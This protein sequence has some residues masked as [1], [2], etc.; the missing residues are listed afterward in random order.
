MQTLQER[1]KLHRQIVKLKSRLQDMGD[2]KKIQDPDAS[3]KLFQESKTSTRDLVYTLAVWEQEMLKPPRR[4]VHHKLP[5]TQIESWNKQI[6][7]QKEQLLQQ[8]STRLQALQECQETCRSQMQYELHSRKFNV[9]QMKE[10]QT[11]LQSEIRQ[12]VAHIYNLSPRAS[13]RLT[14][15]EEAK[16]LEQPYPKPPN[17][18]LQDTLLKQHILPCPRTDECEWYQCL[19][20]KWCLCKCQLRPHCDFCIYD[21]PSTMGEQRKTLADE[22]I[23]RMC[24]PVDIRQIVSTFSF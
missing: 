17:K 5:S 6:A 21:D 2:E 7:R 4:Q 9:I 22:D 15:K 23:A 1:W 16:L 12:V 18:K 19:L 10:C 11:F 14:W 20:C 13:T 8:L 3:D 24:S